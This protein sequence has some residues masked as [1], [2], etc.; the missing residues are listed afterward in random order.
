MS[1]KKRNSELGVIVPPILVLAE[2]HEVF[3]RFWR[4]AGLQ[5]DEAKWIHALDDIRGF[6]DKTLMTVGYFGNIGDVH[7]IFDYAKQHNIRIVRA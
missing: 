2:T 5:Q 1:K 7:L 6:Q 4:Q 3:E